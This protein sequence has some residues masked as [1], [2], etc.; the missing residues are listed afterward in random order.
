[1]ALAVERLRTETSRLAEE[2]RSD[3]LQIGLSIARKVIGLEI[4]AR[5]E[6]LIALV[7]S[8]IEEAG[9]ER[10]VELRLPQ[11]DL[12]RIEAQLEANPHLSLSAAQ[13]KL[14]ADPSLSAG[15][16]LVVTDFGHV[17]GRLEA[18]IDRL[19]KAI[20]EEGGLAS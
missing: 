10:V 14:V 20:V 15:D 2:A 12:S 16:C 7:R 6:P 4:S 19:W 5:V 3:A 11:K 9:A 13:V 8:A 18:R 1:M 17:D